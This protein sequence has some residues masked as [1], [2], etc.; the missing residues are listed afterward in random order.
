M[1]RFVIALLLAAFTALPGIAAQGFTFK[2]I[3]GG[4]LSLDQWKGQPVLVV[5]T[6][7][8]CGFTPQFDGLQAL[9]DA[10]RDQGLIVLAVPSNDFKQELASEEEVKEFC[11]FNFNLDMPMTTINHVRGQDAHPFYG[12]VEARTGFVPSWNFNKILIG[13]EGDVL[14]TW[15]AL[16]TPQSASIINA[17][18]AALR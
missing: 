15:G 12:W 6:A 1:F 7:S 11:E 17:V 10:Y 4:T 16:T 3:D 13:P 5:N 14:G 8:R 9:Y 2:S 18:K